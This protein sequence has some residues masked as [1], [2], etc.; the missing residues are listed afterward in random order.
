MKNPKWVIGLRPMTREFLDWYGQRNW[1]KD[2]VVRTM[3][4]IDSPAP[5]SQLTPGQ[6]TLGGVAY[7]G[8]RGI[9]R[10][11]YSTD[12]GE[13]WQDATLLDSPPG[14]DVWTR[15]QGQLQLPPGGGGRVAI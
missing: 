2:A 6:N 7:A 15:W 10:V 4:R 13:S 9:Q 8:T 5:D 12:G 1:S 14:Q 11:E 3:S